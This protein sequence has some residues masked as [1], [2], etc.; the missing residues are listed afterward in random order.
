[1]RG[2]LAF[3]GQA[4]R[5]ATIGAFALMALALLA[6]VIARRVFM[7]GLVGATEIAVIG[8]VAVAMFGIGVATDAGAHLRPRLFDALIPKS[9]E[10]VMDRLVSAVTAVFF[11]LFAGLAVWMVGE[12][13]LLGDRTEI[14]RLPVWALQVMIALAFISN[15]I[16]FAAYAAD[17]SLKPSE[18]IEEIKE[19]AAGAADLPD[20]EPR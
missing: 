16:R 18:D 7:T 17:P 13:A 12:S 19:A 10:A 4:E 9:A 5:W 20:Q 15:F 1:M 14:L 2:L 3:I 6:D 8:M 11:A